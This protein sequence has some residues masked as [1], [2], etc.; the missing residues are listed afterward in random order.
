VDEARVQ[1]GSDDGAGPPAPVNSNAKVPMNSAKNLGAIRLDIL[2]SRM[3]VRR[4]H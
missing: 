3:S 4:S 2:I 1:D